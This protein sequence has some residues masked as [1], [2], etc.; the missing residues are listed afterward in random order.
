MPECHHKD[1]TYSRRCVLHHE[2]EAL[3]YYDQ[4]IM[5]EAVV[6]LAIVFAIAGYLTTVPKDIQ[7]YFILIGILVVGAAVLRRQ[8]MS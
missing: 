7:L 8:Y 6:K 4:V 1:N 3:R 2:E 5:L